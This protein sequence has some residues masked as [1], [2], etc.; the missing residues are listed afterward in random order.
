MSNWVPLVCKLKCILSKHQALE[1]T[2][3]EENKNRS[4]ECVLCKVFPG[5]S[6]FQWFANGR[7]LET[8]REIYWQAEH[9]TSAV[10]CRG[11]YWAGTEKDSTVKNQYICW[12]TFLC[13]QE[14]T[15]YG[16]WL[17]I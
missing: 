5:N 7:N 14:T 3:W 2:K 10:L 1:N 4:D 13:V 16:S 12:D 8:K 9:I 15:A 17:N 6:E 11:L